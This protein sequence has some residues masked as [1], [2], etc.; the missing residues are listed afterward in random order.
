[1]GPARAGR[2]ERP[3]AGGD[4]PERQ[5]AGLR[6]QCA[7][8][9][10]R[11]DAAL[12]EAAEAETRCQQSQTASTPTSPV[13]QVHSMEVVRTPSAR[14][15][16]ARQRDYVER[17]GAA[18]ERGAT[19]GA[20]GADLRKRL[21]LEELELQRCCAGA[22]AEESARMRLEV[23]LALQEERQ[24]EGETMKY[25]DGSLSVQR[26]SEDYMDDWKSSR[27]RDGK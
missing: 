23:G 25:K 18:E 20:G 26:A 21:L 24:Q 17:W 8:L 4:G 19:A 12:Q 11:L 22:A 16:R 14:W 2:G 3:A 15:A 13:S 9:Q 27:S 6:Q 10:G 1:D 7:S 5:L